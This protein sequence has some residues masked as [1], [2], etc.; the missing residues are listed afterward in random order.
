MLCAATG[1]PLGEILE[2][3]RRGLHFLMNGVHQANVTL[4]LDDPL[5]ALVEPGR[6]RLKVYGR[7]LTAVP[8]YAGAPSTLAF[9]G[10]LPAENVREAAA[11]NEMELTFCDPRWVLSR[12]Y[13]LNP[14]PLPVTFGGD[15]G[16]ILWT[17][18]QF[19]NDFREAGETWIRE[20]AVTTGLFRERTFDRQLL[21]ELFESMTQVIDGPDHDVEPYDGFAEASV[22]ADTGVM[23][24]LNVFARQGQDRSDAHFAYGEGLV[25]NCRD[26]QRTFQPLT[27]FATFTGTDTDTSATLV[28]AYGTPTTEGFGVL[29]DYESDPDITERATLQEKARGRV[30]ERQGLRP[31]IRIVEPFVTGPFPL[32]AL[33][34]FYLGDT[35]YASCSRGALVFSRLPQRIHGIDIDIDAEG[36]DTVNLTTMSA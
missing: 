3:R 1:E 8:W 19:Q 7:E 11:D 25:A 30:L 17:L 20:G 24:R 5:A 16:W 13:H 15:Q 9:Y 22:P 21:A 12:R 35:V 29:E 23:A 31:V 33:N 18:V 26:M 2:A 10:S 6:T 34:D 36:R 32:R 27:T 4:T 28:E 14:N